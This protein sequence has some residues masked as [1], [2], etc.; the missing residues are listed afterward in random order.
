MFTWF[1]L[2]LSTIFFNQHYALFYNYKRNPIACGI[3][4]LG[5]DHCSLLGNTLE[6]IAW[7]KAG[8]I[9]VNI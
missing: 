9:K 5:L 8:I 3:S 6:E 1:F 7:Q 4:S 2:K